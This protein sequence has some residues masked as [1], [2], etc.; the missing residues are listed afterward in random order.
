MNKNI[1]HEFAY[2]SRELG[3]QIEDTLGD[4]PDRKSYARVIAALLGEYAK[5]TEID[6]V[7]LLSFALADYLRFDD[8][9]GLLA[10]SQQYEGGNAA[11]VVAMVACTDTD[12]AKALATVSVRNPDLARKAIITAFLFKNTKRWAAED[13]SSEDLQEEEDGDNKPDADEAEDD[14]RNMPGQDVIDLFDTRE[15]GNV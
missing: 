4:P 8:P 6:D 7:N 10:Q 2:Q 3:I 15:D 5:G 9:A 11:Q 14:E 13:K 1:H 12:A